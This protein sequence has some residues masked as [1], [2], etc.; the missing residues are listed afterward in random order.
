MTAVLNNEYTKPRIMKRFQSIWILIFGTW[1]LL[2]IGCGKKSGNSQFGFCSENI[3]LVMC[4]YNKGDIAG[5][6]FPYAN[7]YLLVNNTSDSLLTL[8]KFKY[9]HLKENDVE[10]MFVAKR[11]FKIEI[12]PHD[13]AL[14]KLSQLYRIHDTSAFEAPIILMFNESDTCQVKIHH[15]YEVYNIRNGIP[16]NQYFQMI[17]Y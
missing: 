17:P 8:K 5:G 9:H 1:L 4:G 16:K 15:E 3:S 14:I 12:P 13:S 11:K 6:H 10:M 2:I 7:F